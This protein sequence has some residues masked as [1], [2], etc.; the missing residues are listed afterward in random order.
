MANRIL[1]L[2]STDILQTTF[3]P[4]AVLCCLFGVTFPWP[5][6]LFSMG[7]Q[8]QCQTCEYPVACLIYT[9]CTKHGS[10]MLGGY[11]ACNP[12]FRLT[13]EAL[14]DLYTSTNLTAADL[15]CVRDDV[16]CHDV[17]GLERHGCT[18]EGFATASAKDTYCDPCM[19]EFG[20]ELRPAIFTST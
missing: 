16:V 12:G 15:A 2:D 13:V 3:G 20:C 19:L 4:R 6:F 1:P 9:E 11:E 14:E 7:L 8:A 5:P 17:D 18:D 10:V